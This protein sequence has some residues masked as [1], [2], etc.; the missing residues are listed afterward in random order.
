MTSQQSPFQAPS[1]IKL[2]MIYVSTLPF[3]LHLFKFPLSQELT[4]AFGALM[5]VLISGFLF[6]DSAHLLSTEPAL[7]SS[8][9]KVRSGSLL[10]QSPSCSIGTYSSLRPFAEGGK[11]DSPLYFTAPAQ[12]QSLRE[13]DQLHMS[14]C[15]GAH[16]EACTQA[17]K[18]WK[19]H[20]DLG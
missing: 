9:V 2:F 12:I 19:G 18:L 16:R 10:I 1:L 14:K 6:M 5:L 17:P 15:S 4:V 13:I 3:S 20:R 8:S 11:L 7:Q